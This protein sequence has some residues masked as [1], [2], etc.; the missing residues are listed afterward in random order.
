MN[1]VKPPFLLSKLTKNNLIWQIQTETPI[2]YLTFDDGPIPEITPFVLKT[3]RDFN[4]KA[5]FFCVG[6]NVRKHPDIFNEIVVSGHK[7]GNHTF[8]H[9]N[10]WKTHSSNYIENIEKCNDYFTTDLFRPPYGKLKP[11]QVLDIRKTKAII[12]WSVLSYDFDQH[13][14]KEECLN[15][16]LSFPDKGAIVVFHDN[17][18]AKDNMFFALPRFLEHFTNKGFTFEILTKALCEETLS[19]PFKILKK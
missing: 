11:S 2:I 7:I 16:A 9:L 15:N 13:I 1:F 5:T 10:G 3:L 17:I 12:L 18:K 14:T 4:A 6:D 8:N 19:K